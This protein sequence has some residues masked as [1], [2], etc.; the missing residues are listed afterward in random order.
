MWRKAMKVVK[1]KESGEMVSYYAGKIKQG[2]EVSYDFGKVTFP[3]PGCRPLLAF[4]DEA[5]AWR[6]LK[7]EDEPDATLIVA[8]L[9]NTTTE[10]PKEGWDW[11]QGTLFCKE[12]VLLRNS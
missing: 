5:A 9:V 10:N 11:S 1:V 6:F 2:L 3:M 12:I 4:R 7:S 8:C